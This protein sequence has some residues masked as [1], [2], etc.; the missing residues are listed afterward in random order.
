MNKE[1]RSILKMRAVAM[2]KAPEEIKDPSS[3]N[4]FIDFSL[5]GENY[6]VESAFVKEVCP[7]KDFTLLPDVPSY[8]IGIV[9]VRGR[10]LPIIDLKSF[11]N[12]PKKGLGE[13]NKII[14]LQD[15]QMEFGILA[16]QINQTTA[17][18]TDEILPVP[19]TI[20]GI[21]EK[22]VTGIT[23]DRMILLSAKNLLNDKTIIVYD[24]VNP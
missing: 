12:L 9:N 21:G 20:K 5:G 18:F 7:L 22:Y 1:T 15:E 10:I 23:K 17:I 3:M 11:F 19:R 24:E 4:W 16:D 6:A 13:L 8:I 2:A 14:I